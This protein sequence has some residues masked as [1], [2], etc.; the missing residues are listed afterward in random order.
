MLLAGPWFCASA[1][2]IPVLRSE[3]VR[4]SSGQ[5][6]I[7]AP[8]L[9]GPVGN[10]SLAGRK[11]DLLQLEPG[12]VG[13]SCERIRQAL[14]RELGP[15]GPW[16]GKI[17]VEVQMGRA[18]G[19]PVTITSERF[20]NGWQYRLQLPATVERERYT[21]AVVQVL[22]MELANRG[23]SGRLAEIPAWLSEGLTE[24]LLAFNRLEIILPPP[25]STVN[26][27]SFAATRATERLNDPVAHARQQL[28]GQ[29]PLTFD[30]L[31]WQAADQLSGDAAQVYRAS[32]EMFLGELLRFRDGPTCLAAMLARLPAYYNWQLAFLNAFRAHFERTLDVEKW[33]ALCCMQSP[34]K[35][36]ARTLSVEATWDDLNLALITPEP[37]R[38]AG[39]GA[40]APAYTSLQTVIREWDRVRQRQVLSNKLQE[41]ALLRTR[42]PSE[43]A[44]LVQEYC[45][46]IE[47]Y[48]EN[49][50]WS[51]SLKLFTGGSR[52]SSEA[53]DT[54]ARLDALDVRRL[55]LRH[56]TPALTAGDVSAKPAP[57]P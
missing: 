13:V 40:S 10:A 24:R 57:R 15:T 30:Q 37:G 54:I 33:W 22:L 28:N 46:A 53:K 52:L 21:R 16:Q 3:S 11:G 4:S 56:P 8:G 17:Y 19:Q 25:R 2:Q 36:L 23:S 47:I 26:G 34:D 7:Q 20:L 31:S 42:L 27:V 49:P 5:F 45:E 43:L 35:E 32:A 55:G 14:L 50:H 6:I 12:F 9:G 29:T 18:A 1:A 41:L 44:M 51:A 39:G 48:L 38:A